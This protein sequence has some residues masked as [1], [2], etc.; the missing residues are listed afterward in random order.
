M[1]FEQLV[2]NVVN[3]IA[4]AN[5]S[6]LGTVVAVVSIVFWLVV[7]SWIWVDSDER[8]TSKWMRLFYVIIGIIP[9]IGWI[10]YLIVRPT[11]TIDEIYWGDLE[12]RYL[13]Y[14]AK[15][16]GD[17]E[18]CG[19][20][21]YPGFV[22]CPNCGK[23]IKRKCSNCEVY[24]DLEYKYCPNCG[25]KM[26]KKMK[27]EKEI[28]QEEMKKQIDETKEEAHETVKSKKSKYKQEQNFLHGVGESIIKGYKLLGKKVKKLFEKKVPEEKV[29]DVKETSKKPK[30]EQKENK[31]Q[32]NN[33]QKKKEQK[34]V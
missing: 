4:E 25:N 8:T 19:T 6:M 21:L 27:K 2:L 11:E 23:R 20:Q 26:Q 3:G 9:V 14:E 31:K 17:C 16:L 29:E 28:S 12:R 30:K 34:S 15:D 7:T 5:Y 22:F 10:I 1:D 24:V 13:K 32:N 33:Q 18:R